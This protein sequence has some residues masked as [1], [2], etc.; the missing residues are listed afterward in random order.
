LPETIYWFQYD[1][2][3]RMTGE[4][5]HVGCPPYVVAPGGSA[6]APALPGGP[7]TLSTAALPGFGLVQGSVALVDGNGT[8]YG[9]SVTTWTAAQIIATLPTTTPGPEPH[10][11]SVTTST[12][13]DCRQ[14][15]FLVGAMMG[16]GQPPDLTALTAQILA[17]TQVEWD[18]KYPKPGEAIEVRVIPGFAAFLP[19]NL[20]GNLPTG[21]NLLLSAL[22]N[23]IDFTVKYDVTKADGSAGP[24]HV[25]KPLSP[26]LLPNSDPLEA[27]VTILP[28]F[29]DELAVADA[30]TLHLNVH[31]TVTI[32]GISKSGD[33]VI[34]IPIPPVPVPAVLLM[35]KDADHKGELVLLVRT[36]SA[37]SSAGQIVST[38]NSIIQVANSVRDIVD[39]ATLLTPLHSAVDTITTASSLAGGVAA[40]GIS[41]LEDY[42][43]MDNEISSWLLI[44]LKG[45]RVEFWNSSD[46][47]GPLIGE[48][49][50]TTV[51]LGE[52]SGTVPG[53]STMVPLGIGVDE[54]KNLSSKPWDDSDGNDDMN[55]DIV[56]VRFI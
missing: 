14:P 16:A 50:K 47:D 40:G 21:G 39:M 15:I 51:T 7:I 26:G 34:P 20:S 28:P 32:E 46:F 10:A 41:D 42:D 1:G 38:L 43:E 12:D 22:V 53:T 37:L 5:D 45:T 19:P 30:L 56:S 25:V 35:S 36:G 9:L 17:L 29:V 44:G 8:Q 31:V 52:L 6:A 33:V 11:V 49:H 18:P 13:S 48:T 55:D 54:Q 24:G 2:V 27:L 4:A 23:D 3:S